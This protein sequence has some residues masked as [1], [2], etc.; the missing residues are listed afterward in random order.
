MEKLEQWNSHS[1]RFVERNGEWWAVLADIAKALDLKPKYVKERYGLNISIADII[2]GK[3]CW[4]KA[5]KKAWGT[6][7]NQNETWK[8]LDKTKTLQRAG[9][10]GFRI[11]FYAYIIA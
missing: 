1:I 5:T 7:S 8:I 10:E 2:Y 9:Y 3:T 6:N 11:I 4:M